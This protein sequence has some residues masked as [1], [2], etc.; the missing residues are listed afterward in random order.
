MTCVLVERDETK[1]K[2]ITAV[3]SRRYVMKPSCENETKLKLLK[4]G[5][6]R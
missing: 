4:I 1:S 3:S 5:E 6:Q 2:I